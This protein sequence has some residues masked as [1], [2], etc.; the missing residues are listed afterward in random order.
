MHTSI[1]TD[2]VDPKE[3]WAALPPDAQ[4][5]I[6]AAAVAH[7]LG[8]FGGNEGLA[9]EQGYRA[10]EMEGLFLLDVDLRHFAPQAFDNARPRRPRLTTLGIQSCRRCGC[11]QE[12]GCPEGCYWVEE[13]LC[14]SCQEAAQR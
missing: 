10:A 12:C 1:P 5:R 6:G 14:S 13:D 3:I 7:A 4:A 11:T 9:P 8:T 2:T